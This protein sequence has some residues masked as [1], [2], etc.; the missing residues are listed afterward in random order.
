MIKVF[1]R[2]KFGKRH[3]HHINLKDSGVL[4][5]T[6]CVRSVQKHLFSVE[7]C[8]TKN[9]GVHQVQKCLQ[10]VLKKVCRTYFGKKRRNNIRA[11]ASTMLTFTIHLNYVPRNLC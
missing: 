6:I 3:R 1:L 11:I 2:N 8:Y 7:L 5:F 9:S 4:T 10:K